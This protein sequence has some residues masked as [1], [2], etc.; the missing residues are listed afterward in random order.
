MTRFHIR[1][2][3]ILSYFKKSAGRIFLFMHIFSRKIPESYEHVINIMS[4][5]YTKY[6][7]FL[8]SYLCF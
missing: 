3:F 2:I 7:R 6:L 4:I 5:N 8:M 1:S